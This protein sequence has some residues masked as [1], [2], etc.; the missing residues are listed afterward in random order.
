M[1]GKSKRR[2]SRKKNRL[3]ASGRMIK[4]ASAAF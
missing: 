2:P 4:R 1:F 3:N